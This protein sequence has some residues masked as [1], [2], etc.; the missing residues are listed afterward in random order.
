MIY[1]LQVLK[2]KPEI[3]IGYPQTSKTVSKQYQA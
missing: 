3:H 2:N 1:I